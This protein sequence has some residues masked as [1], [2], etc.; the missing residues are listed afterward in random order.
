MNITEKI[1]A[2]HANQREVVPNEIVEVDVDWCML[3]D[4]TITITKDIFYNQFGFKQVFDKNKVVFIMDHRIPADS[5][6][7]A[8]GQ[9]ISRTFGRELGIKIHENDGVCHQIMLENYV[10][11]AELIVAAD[12]HTC[13]YGCV[14]AVSVGMG[15]TDIAAV[16]GTGKTWFKVPETMKI[17]LTGKLKRGVY[18]KD[19]ILYIIRQIS[20]SGATYKAVEFCGEFTNNLSISERFTICNMVIEAG[21][22]SAM[23]SPNE[24]IKK[25]YN[26]NKNINWELLKPDEGAK[27]SEI[28]EYD[29]SDI[30][31]QVACPHHVDNVKDIADVIGTEINQAFLGGCVN[32]KLDDLEIAAKLLKNKKVNRDVRLLIVPSS[33]KIYREAI[34]K[35]YID[36]FLDA[37]ATINHPGCST[38]WGASVGSLAPGDAMIS[39]GTRNF[40]GR[41]GSKDSEVYLASPATVVASAIKGAITNPSEEEMV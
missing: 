39:S 17:I 41:A 19:V 37:G 20:C 9:E 23:I 13:S 8:V 6:D 26:K 29:V 11:P 5:I 24:Q 18:A 14:G 36:I 16:M 25:F 34:K 3:N 10:Q 35:G 32:G 27:Y 40:R 15:S 1:I 7:T 33:V 2:A 21:G 12:S 4:A 22:K 28:L 30:T 38:C 31:A